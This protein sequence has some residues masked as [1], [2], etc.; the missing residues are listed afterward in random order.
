MAAKLTRDK[1]YEIVGRG[2]LDDAQLAA[3][4]ATGA[5]EDELLEAMNRTL[6]TGV[7]AETRRP[8][9]ARVARLC[10]ILGVAQEESWGDEP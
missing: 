10:E 8:L 1:V 5:N 4:I 7:G 6:R 9:S 3:V 2:R